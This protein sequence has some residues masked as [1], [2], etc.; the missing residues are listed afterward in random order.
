MSSSRSPSCSTRSSSGSIQ[1][2][3]LCLGHPLL[4]IQAQT[5]ASSLPPRGLQNGRECRH[6]D[7]YFPNRL[8][9]LKQFRTRGRVDFSGGLCGAGGCQRGRSCAPWKPYAFQNQ[10]QLRGL[11]ARRGLGVGPGAGQREATRSNR[12]AHTT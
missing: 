12:L 10:A 1:L 9:F 8:G 3:R 5:L 11:N 2:R 6:R 7:C 4:A